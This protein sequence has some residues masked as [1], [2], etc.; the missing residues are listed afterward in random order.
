MSVMS[1]ARFRFKAGRRVP[2]GVVVVIAAEGQVVRQKD[3]QLEPNLPLLREERGETGDETTPTP[4][5][6]L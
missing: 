3:L 4:C 1:R 5:K 2:I 6:M